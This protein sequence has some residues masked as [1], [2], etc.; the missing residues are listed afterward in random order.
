MGSTIIEATPEDLRD[1]AC[2]CDTT[3]ANIVTELD[4]LQSKLDGLGWRGEARDAFDDLFTDMHKKL[5]A[6]QQQLGSQDGLGLLLNRTA[7]G[8]DANETAMADG[9]HQ[10]QAG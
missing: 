7:D 2:A 3:G 1:G 9:F 5:T 8:Y 4:N 6:I 10:M